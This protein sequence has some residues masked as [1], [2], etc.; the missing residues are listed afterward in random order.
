MQASVLKIRLFF[1]VH[2]LDKLHLFF[3]CHS[4]DLGNKILHHQLLLLHLWDSFFVWWT[5]FG[6][7]S[8]LLTLKT[9]SFLHEIVSFFRCQHIEIDF[10]N[11]PLLFG[12]QCLSFILFPFILGSVPG[13]FGHDLGH[14]IVGVKLNCLGNP[15]FNRLWYNF[16]KQ[17][18]VCELRMKGFS[19]QPYHVNVV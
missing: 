12:F 5:I 9:S 19:E 7:M 14:S 17:D 1:I 4:L 15:S 13:L 3:L 16:S 10:I 2:Q 8:P 18:S 6:Y 11:I